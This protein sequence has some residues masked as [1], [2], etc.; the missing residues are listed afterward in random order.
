MA[1]GEASVTEADVKKKVALIEQKLEELKSTAKTSVWVGRAVLLIISIV[2]IFQVVSIYAIFRQVKVDWDSY[3]KTA[4]EEIADRI[5]PKVQ[6]EMGNLAEKLLPVYQQA[7]IRE[8]DNGMPEVAEKFNEEANTFILNVGTKVQKSLD[9]RFEVVL[10]KQINILAEDMPELKDDKKRKEIKDQI[11]DAAYSA[12]Q[13][14]SNDLFKPQIEAV[15]DLNATLDSSRS[16]EKFVEMNDTQLLYHTSNN[17][18]KLLMVKL[19]ILEDVFEEPVKI[20]IK[21]KGK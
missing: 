13:H 6:K 11:L 12:A 8:F 16:P 1:R 4:Q 10:N 17:I 18:G 15:A 20:E 21:T 14:L 3:T 9:T 7:F 2:I 19:A 5:L